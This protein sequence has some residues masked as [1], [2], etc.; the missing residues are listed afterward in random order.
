MAVANHFDPVNRSVKDEAQKKLIG[1][2]EEFF[3]SIFKLEKILPRIDSTTQTGFVKRRYIL[4]NLITYWESLHWAK[5]SRKNGAMLLIDFEKAYARIEWE[6]IIQMLH[7]LGFPA[8]FCRMVK[9]LLSDANAS[10]EVHGI[11]S[12]NFALT[13]LIR[14]GCP[15]ALALFVLVVDAMFYILKDFSITPPVKAISLPNRDEIVNIQFADDTAIL[16][17]LEEDNLDA[18]LKN[19][20]L[21]CLASGSRIALHKSSLLG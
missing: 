6:Y 16:L 18:L 15:L 5:E 9:T 17:N 7:S 3:D 8:E 2:D 14:Q 21:F 10:V 4:E 12:P 19:I 1:I 13:R 20:E 11:R